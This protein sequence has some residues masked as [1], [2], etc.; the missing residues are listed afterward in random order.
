MSRFDFF[1]ERP[2]LTWMLTLSL[3]VFGILGYARLGVDQFPNLEFPVVTVIANLEGASPEVVEQDVTDVLEEYLT[4][5]AGVRKIESDTQQGEAT[6]RIEFELGLDLDVATQDVRDKVAQAR[7]W[8]P[9]D[10]E[11]PIVIKEDPGDEPVVW[12]PVS[13]SRPTVWPSMTFTAHR[14]PV[15]VWMA[16]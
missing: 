13:S 3:L 12:I 16:S 8:L 1:I 6:V 15:T 14:R 4:T 2:V 10:A 5:I 11:P 9:K 7:Y